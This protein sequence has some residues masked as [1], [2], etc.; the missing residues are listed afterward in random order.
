MG[1]VLQFSYY[2]EKTKKSLQYHGSSVDL[3]A[4]DVGVLCTW[5][6][7][8][9]PTAVFGPNDNLIEYMHKSESIPF[10]VCF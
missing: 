5:F 6:V 4:K 9:T 1:R 8:I 7:K 3:F 2:Q 10:N